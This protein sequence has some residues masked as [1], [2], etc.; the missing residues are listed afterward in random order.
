MS[1][2]FDSVRA[3][4]GAARARGEEGGAAARTGRDT[5]L[6][7]GA[8]PNGPL[9]GLNSF[10]LLVDEPEVY[11]LPR[12]PKMPSRNNVKRSLLSTFGAIVMAFVGALTL[13][14][15]PD[16]RGREDFER[17]G[18]IV[19]TNLPSTFFTAPPDFGWAIILYFFIGGIGGGALMLAGLLRLFGRTE[20]RAYI[21]IASAMAL[22]SAVISG[23]L[24]IVDLSSPL[25][26]WHMV[27]QNHTLQP[28]FKWWSPMSVGVWILIAFSG[29]AFL[30]TLQSFVEE[31]WFP[32]TVARIAHAVTRPALVTVSAI[33]GIISGLGLAGYTG[34]LLAATNRPLWSD[35][36]WLGVLFLFSA[37]STSMAA[38]LLLSRWR[39]VTESPT[40]EWLARF[41]NI[42]L[43]FELLALAGF[44]VSL[45]DA[46]TALFNAWGVLLVLGV[47]VVGI[48]VP[49]FIQRRPSHG[50]VLPAVLVLVGGFLLRTVILLSSEQI[51]VVGTQVIR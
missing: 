29:F 48:L 15:E 20:D 25:R 43:V 1:D 47:V 36:S 32:K 24:L 2:G 42:T 11:G 33:G 7:Y 8:D 13:A 50:V 51:H 5:R 18:V 49:F 3:H 46:S 39:R 38:L 9:G 35:S 17:G 40:R 30:A 26:F 44:L 23:L 27:V 6:L 14:R 12:D 34:I 4:L 19:Q 45:G 10:Y 21:Q 37:M 28:M 31:P 41:D 22:A 16:A